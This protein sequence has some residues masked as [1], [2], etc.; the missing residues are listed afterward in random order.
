MLFGWV[1]LALFSCFMVA[2]LFWYSVCLLTMICFWLL[3]LVTLLWVLDLIGWGVLGM[4]FDWLLVSR[5]NV[6]V[7]RCLDG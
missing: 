7:I 4:R 1:L 6:G 5:L 2:C 3:I